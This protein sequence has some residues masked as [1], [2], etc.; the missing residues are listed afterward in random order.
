MPRIFVLSILSLSLVACDLDF[1]HDLRHGHDDHGHAHE[2]ENAHADDH[3]HAHET[4]KDHGDEAEQADEHGHGHEPG[5]IA[6]THFSATTELFVEYPALVIGEESAFAAHLTQLADFRP[7]ASGTFSVHLSSAGAASESFSVDAPSI[8]GIF[9]PIAIPTIAGERQLRLELKADNLSVIHDLGTVQ[10]YADKHSALA[11]QVEEE[12]A[13]SISFLK[14]QQWKVDFA[15]EQVEKRR[16]R[17][18]IPATGN[19]QAR[20]DGEILVSAPSAG[21]LSNNNAFP[22]LGTQVIAG[23]TLAIII[24]KVA[25]DVDVTSLELAVQ[26]AQ[27]QFQLAS[28][29]RKRLADLVA[30]QAA[31]KKRLN[32]A[33]NAER[34]ARA[35]LKA[36]KQRLQQYQRSLNNADAKKQ[37]GVSIRAPISGTLVDIRITAGSFVEQGQ[38]LFH[39]VDTKR[40]WLEA[41]IAEA[42]LGR[43]QNPDSAWFQVEGFKNSFSI[44]AENGGQLIAAG[45]VVDASS[46]TA[47]LLFEFDNSDKHLRVGMFA[48]VHVWTGAAR[49]AVALPVSALVNE[50][51][52]EVAYVM[53]GGE[54]FERRVLRLGIREGDYVEVKSGIEAGER[55][56]SRG[57]YL[58]R[59]A[60]ASPAEAGHGHAH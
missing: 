36:A 8:P 26:R 1:L 32:V 15:L 43:L 49:D 20:S 3:G 42:D 12:E 31:A 37:H 55:V 45:S 17:A 9:R 51:G 40:L 24:P 58:V 25:G 18:S 19:I 46:R 39:I 22:R 38:P 14:E 50:A 60:A 35:D 21:H 44:E 16:L 56:V 13:E 2:A 47:P 6:V 33:E 7:V 53:L 29:E 28:R 30:Q 54:S 34:L 59:L 23:E 4:E 5:A 11:A 57:A 27:A 52:Q 10:V 41:N 48:Q